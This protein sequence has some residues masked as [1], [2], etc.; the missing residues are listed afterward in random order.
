MPHEVYFGQVYSSKEMHFKVS[1]S[2]Y[3]G[4]HACMH[5]CPCVYAVLALAIW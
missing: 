3:L 5:T 1:P 2:L 4:T